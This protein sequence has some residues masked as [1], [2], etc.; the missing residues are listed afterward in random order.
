MSAQTIVEFE[1]QMDRHEEEQEILAGLAEINLTAEVFNMSFEEASA[2]TV[3][4]LESQIASLQ[5]TL[6]QVK[7]AI[8]NK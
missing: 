4:N 8:P 2:F 6:K 1:N 5:K 3:E 7:S